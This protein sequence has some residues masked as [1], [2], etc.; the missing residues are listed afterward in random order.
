MVDGEKLHDGCSALSIQLDDD[1][2]F[3]SYSPTIAGF[4]SGPGFIETL[5]ASLDEAEALW[6]STPQ[7]GLDPGYCKAGG[8]PK[9]DASAGNGRAQ[10]FAQAPGMLANPRW[11]RSAFPLSGAHLKPVSVLHDAVE[12]ATRDL[13]PENQSGPPE[14][15]FNS[16][17]INRYA[18]GNSMIRWHADDEKCYGG[19]SEDPITIA[20]VSL[21][22]ERVF[23]MR[24]KPVNP[25]ERRRFRI[26]LRS[27]S[28]LVLPASA[29][30]R[31][32]LPPRSPTCSPESVRREQVMGGATQ[33]FWEHSLPAE[34][35][36]T[37]TR[38]NCTFRRVVARCDQALRCYEAPRSYANLGAQQQ[39]EGRA[40]TPGQ[41][42][43]L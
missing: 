16:I 23:E 26:L 12:A 22:A 34:P 29:P 24:R 3:L 42:L 36:C 5:R 39:G 37:A 15:R 4:D 28:L 7:R 25:Q 10:F 14:R 20:S 35:A 11:F 41:T 8:P 33:R 1:G 18:D 32:E 27:G 6:H 2:S 31:L 17:L 40:L 21:G 30:P 13:L 19:G 43:E 9:P 38:F